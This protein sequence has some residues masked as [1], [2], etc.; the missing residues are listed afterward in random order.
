MLSRNLRSVEHWLMSLVIFCYLLLF[1]EEYVRFHLPIEYSPM[2]VALWFGNAGAL[3]PCLTSHLMA[4]LTQ[5][6]QKMPKYVYP[7][8][9]YLPVIAV[10]LTLV[11]RENIFNSHE[12]TQVGIWKLPVY[13]GPY[14]TALT[15]SCVISLVYLVFLAKGIAAAKTKEQKGIYYLLIYGIIFV[16]GWTIVFGYISFGKSLPPY[17]YIFAGIGW[18]I[19]LQLTMKRYDFLHYDGKRYEV[20][21]D[22]NPSAILLIDMKGRIKEANPSAERMFDQMD[23]QGL[24]FMDLLSNDDQMEWASY[25]SDDLKKIKDYETVINH[26]GTLL[27]ILI[28]ADYV[29]VDHEPHVILILR[30]VSLLKE[31]QEAI[32]FLAYHDPLTL[33]ANRRYFCNQLEKAISDANVHQEQLAVLLIDLDFFKETNDRYGHKAGD[34]VMQHVARMLEAFVAHIGIAGRL[35]GDEFVLFLSPINHADDVNE[36]IVQLKEQLSRR[37]LF[38]EGDPIPIHMSIGASIYPKDG[39]NMDALLVSADKAMY[40]TKHKRKGQEDISHKNVTEKR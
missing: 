31:N 24:S 39:S 22:L 32:T 29:H 1:L 34:L 33:L 11:R 18:C 12:F 15:I 38:Y 37:P 13:N 3:I 35:G 19:F 16:L 36:F 14:Y 10:I 7:Y 6:D 26:R 4:K 9:F 17:P 25:F 28:D 5:F 21:F 2:L 30:D 8:V 23:L 40:N 20:L 27:H